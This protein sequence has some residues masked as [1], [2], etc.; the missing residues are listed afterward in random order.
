LMIP[1]QVLATK[2]RAESLQ[3][4]VMPYVNG[5]A[6]AGSLAPLGAD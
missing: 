3:P 2:R 4:N 5:R 6:D 1:G